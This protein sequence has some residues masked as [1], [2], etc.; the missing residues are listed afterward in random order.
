VTDHT[1][2]PSV[3]IT[4]ASRGIG[5]QIAKQLAASGMRLTIT[6]R[7]GTALDDVAALLTELGAAQVTCVAADMADA[8]SLPTLIDAHRAAYGDMSALILNA[9]VGTA[10]PIDSYPARR[11]DKTMAVNFGAAFLLIQAALPLLRQAAQ[12]H[13]HVG[14]KVIL[15]SSIAGQYA[16]AGLA[17]YSASK[18][19]A[20]SLADS[21][22]AEESGRGVCA[23]AIAPGY[24]DT[25][26]SAW[27]QDQIPAETMIPPEDVAVL[28][29]S[30]MR[31]SSRSMIGRIVLARA[32]TDGYRA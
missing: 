13:P 25:A 27:V 31:L 16:E 6:A 11:L 17:A 23:T 12:R 18:A 8:E 9:G 19:A 24:V 21:L 5:L 10:G 4:G 7:D 28:V 15:L 1:N 14:A 2:T 32:G 3:L 22:N 20:L 26:M 29:D 30:L